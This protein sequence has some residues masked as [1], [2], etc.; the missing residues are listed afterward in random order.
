MNLLKKFSYVLLSVCS[1]LFVITDAIKTQELEIDFFVPDLLVSTGVE[2]GYIPIYIANY[3][4]EVFGFQFMLKSSRPDLVKFNFQDGGFDT[5]GTLISGF[6]VVETND[7][8]TDQSVLWI[9][10]IADMFYIPGNRDGFYPQ[11]GGVAVKIPY[12]TTHAS[13]TTLNLSSIISL[14]PS[15]D[16]SDPYG[17]TIAF[18]SDGVIDTT[19]LRCESWFEDVCM[20]WIEIED[21][22]NGFDSIYTDTIVMP[23]MDTNKIKIHDGSI[24]LRIMNCDLDGSGFWDITDLV[25]LV[26]F[27]FTTLDI[28]ICPILR[29]D[30]DSDGTIDIADLVYIV[31]Y[32]FN[33]GPAPP[34]YL[35]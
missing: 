32:M 35:K 10:A 8:S 9:M 22:Q 1:F 30:T 23:S 14:G 18:I 34:K 12:T 27:M 5:T 26:D 28:E 11:Q 4:T 21:I 7:R 20:S 2:N 16:F 29:C 24:T 13:Y 33:D 19:Y 15:R 31:E 25:C 17:N 6:E 3:K